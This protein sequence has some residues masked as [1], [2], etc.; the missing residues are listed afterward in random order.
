MTVARE[1]DEFLAFTPLPAVASPCVNICRLQSDGIC[2]GCGR[3]LDE[4]A[5][6]S[7]ATDARRR[8]ILDRVGRT[9]R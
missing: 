1:E 5:E 8:E 4:I 9:C 2:E 6:W 7:T 3:T